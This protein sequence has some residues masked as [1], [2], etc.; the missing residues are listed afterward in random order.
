M[1]CAFLFFSFVLPAVAKD[2]A[3]EFSASGGIY[4]P[5][6]EDYNVYFDG[7]PT[8]FS[9]Q[10]SFLGNSSLAFKLR[11]DYITKRI[12]RAPVYRSATARLYDLRIGFEWRFLRDRRFFPFVGAGFGV[13]EAWASSSLNSKFYG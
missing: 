4:F 11:G 7:Q 13:G 5:T 1:A 10:A 2:R 6:H 3:V 12:N 8:S 9:F